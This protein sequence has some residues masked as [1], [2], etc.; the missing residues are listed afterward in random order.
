MLKSLALYGFSSLNLGLMVAGGYFLGKLLENSY[1]IKNMT[2]SGVLIG[3]LLGF[4]EL[5]RIAFKA[6]SKK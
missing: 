3:L 4:Y 2:I 5:F 1:H 6:G